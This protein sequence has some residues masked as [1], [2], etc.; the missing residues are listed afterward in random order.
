MVGE[1]IKRKKL[2]ESFKKDKKFISVCMLSR[3]NIIKDK[4]I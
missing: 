1:K 4:K 3:I 2:F